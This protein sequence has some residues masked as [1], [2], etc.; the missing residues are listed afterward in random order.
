MI[1][2]LD[3]AEHAAPTIA[4]GIA[5]G[6]MAG[7][8]LHAALWLEMIF[9]VSI[10]TLFALAFSL[11]WPM[12]ERRQHGGHLGGRQSKLEA[13]VPLVAGLFAYGVSVFVFWKLD[14]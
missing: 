12:R 10:A 8:G 4:V 3:I 13:F 7:F 14:I 9:W 5:C 11:L 1:N 6:F 2:W